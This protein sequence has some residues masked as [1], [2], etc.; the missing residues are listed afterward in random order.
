VCLLRGAEKRIACAVLV[1]ILKEREQLEDL[2]VDKRAVLI[3]ILNKQ[4]GGRGLD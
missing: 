1:G 3:W 4:D 2:R